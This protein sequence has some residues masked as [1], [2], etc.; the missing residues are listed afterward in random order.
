MS[1][2]AGHRTTIRQQIERQAVMFK[3]A[4]ERPES[5]EPFLIN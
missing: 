2:C 1:E 5:F 4:L 3:T